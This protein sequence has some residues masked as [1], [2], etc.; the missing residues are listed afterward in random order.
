M[1]FL[2]RLVYH[3]K[4][5]ADTGFLRHGWL[6]QPLGLGQKAITWTLRNVDI[7]ELLNQRHSITCKVIIQCGVIISVFSLCSTVNKFDLSNNFQ[8]IYPRMRAPSFCC[9]ERPE[10]G[11]TILHYYSEREGLEP[12]VIGIVKAVAKHLHNSEV[13]NRQTKH[14]QDKG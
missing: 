8:T 9:T 7:S 6:R 14:R 13:R 4:S 5:V 2:L 3:V 12:I 11:A 1:L 10:D